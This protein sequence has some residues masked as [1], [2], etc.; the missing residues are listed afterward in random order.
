MSR[1]RIAYVLLALLIAATTAN[2][3]NFI[4]QTDGDWSTPATW[5]ETTET[6]GSGD[7]VY[8]NHNV[9][10]DAAANYSL[11]TYVQTGGTFTLEKSY[12]PYG[13]FCIQGGTLDLAGH[14]AE[15]ATGSAAFVAR[16]ATAVLTDSVGGGYFGPG[17]GSWDIDGGADLLLHAELRYGGA[18][19]RL[20][21]D[22]FV[23]ADAGG[24]I[25]PSSTQYVVFNG[26]TITL[27]HAAVDLGT[28]TLQV[29]GDRVAELNTKIGTGELVILNEGYDISFDGTHTNVT[30]VPEP[31][32]LVVL[33]LGLVGLAARRR[34]KR[35][36]R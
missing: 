30:A 12:S 35:M 6:P 22:V 10:Y 23:D 13:E 28:L 36:S 19:L 21:G 18:N 16:T 11:I 26:G 17:S 15:G 3:A 8:V 31:S 25:R 14:V 27:D 5:G 7:G 9:Q 34:R 4:S 29:G 24:W 20:Y 2:A 33:G 1:Q 32:A